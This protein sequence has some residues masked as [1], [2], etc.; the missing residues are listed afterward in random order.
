MEEQLD[1]ERED[2]RFRINSYESKISEMEKKYKYTEE[3]LRENLKKASDSNKTYS[4][5]DADK[6][7]R[8]RQLEDEVS[9]LTR[10]L[11][12]EKR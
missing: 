5:S 11:E 7:A 3:S 4:L 8:I 9:Q 10:Q 12:N 2:S 1:K 6:T